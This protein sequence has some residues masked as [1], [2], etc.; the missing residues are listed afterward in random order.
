MTL[1]GLLTSCRPGKKQGVS[2]TR[3]NPVSRCS[4]RVDCRPR[5]DGGP[6]RASRRPVRRSTETPRRTQ[7]RSSSSTKGRFRARSPRRE[8]GGADADEQPRRSGFRSQRRRNI[9]IAEV[10]FDIV[11]LSGRAREGS[12][13]R[14]CATCARGWNARRIG[15]GHRAVA[16]RIYFTLSGKEFAAIYPADRQYTARIS[17]PRWPP[18]RR[19][20]R[21]SEERSRRPTERG[22]HR[23]RSRTSSTRRSSGCRY[24]QA[25]GGQDQESRRRSSRFEPRLDQRHDRVGESDRR[26]RRGVTAQFG[27]DAVRMMPISSQAC[28]VKASRSPGSMVR[29]PPTATR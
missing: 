16:A 27:R 20:Y 25:V 3:R 18:R 17:K 14:A 5:S 23:G 12:Q 7:N 24:R 8:V 19:R 13:R 1:S 29:K 9:V 11:R 10:N 2:H 15:P 26:D 4:H 6:F 28:R 21:L 22:D